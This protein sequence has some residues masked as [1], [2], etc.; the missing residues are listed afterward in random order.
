MEEGVRRVAEERP[1]R[2]QGRVGAVDHLKLGRVDV[3]RTRR[4][5][6][7][8]RRIQR[9]GLQN[10]RPGDVDL[11]RRRAQGHRVRGD[12]QTARVGDRRPVIARARPRA[13]VQ[14]QSPRRRV[15]VAGNRQIIAARAGG[16]GGDRRRARRRGDCDP[17]DRVDVVGDRGQRDHAVVQRRVQTADDPRR[18]LRQVARRRQVD[19]KRVARAATARL[20]SEL[21]LANPNRVS[22]KR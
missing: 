16:L 4:I 7:A 15:D 8:D 1:D 18:G 14:G 2:H 5:R 20:T 22:V 19:R 21:C 6:H 11:I 13:Q 12:R 10:H 9:V 17:G 3:E